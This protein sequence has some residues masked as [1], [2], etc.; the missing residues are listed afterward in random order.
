MHQPLSSILIMIKTKIRCQRLRTI[1]LNKLP[2]SLNSFVFFVMYYS[3]CLQQVKSTLVM[4]I[5]SAICAFVGVVLFLWDLNINGYNNQN[6]VMVVSTLTWTIW[7]LSPQCQSI[8]IVASY[9][10]YSSSIEKSLSISNPTPRNVIAKKQ[11]EKITF[12]D[13]WSQRDHPVAITETM[14]RAWQLQNILRISF[15]AL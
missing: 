10:L 6:Y 13:R 4:N 8:S 9:L 1:N 11:S 2:L 5:I 12:A 3:Y 7:L 14:D 15:S